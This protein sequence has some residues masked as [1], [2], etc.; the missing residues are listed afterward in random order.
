VC[1]HTAV[2][3]V[4]AFC[5]Y[6]AMF[7]FYKMYDDEGYHLW[8]LRLFATGHVLYN[9]VFSSYGPFPYELW[10]AI[11]KLTGATVSTNNGRLA[12]MALWL[13]TSVLLAVTT[14]RLTG[15]LTL[16]VVVQILSFSVLTP[17]V[18]EPMS[19]GGTGLL[20][21]CALLAVA[22][23]ALRAHPRRALSAIGALVAA[24]LL[25]KT[26]V[27]AYTALAVGYAA[28]MTL[29][30]GKWSKIVR[31]AAI[32]AVVF[33]GPAVMIPTF[34]TAWTR[35]FA[36]LVA[37]STVAVVLAT[38]RA[39]N[40]TAPA[41]ETRLWIGWML[42]GF[43]A[44]FAVILGVIFALGTTPR[45]LYDAV[46]VAASRQVGAFTFPLHQRAY[47]VGWVCAALGMAWVVRRVRT[48][49]PGQQ[50]WLAVFR[51]AAGL[52]LWYA[53]AGALRVGP[54]DPQLAWGLPLAWV[55]AV[56]SSR[57]D[58]SLACGFVRRLLPMLTVLQALIAYPVAGTQRAFGS[59]LLLVCGAIC[60]ADGWTELQTFAQS[61]SRLHTRRVVRVLVPAL[62]TAFA[63]VLAI[64]YVGRPARVVHKTYDSGQAL[65]FRS[66]TRL[67]L[68]PKEVRMYADLIDTLQARC[69]SV[70]TLPGMLSLNE[71]SG[72]P[73]PSGMTEQSWWSLLSDSQLAVA[74][75]SAESTNG[76]CLVRNDLLVHF[77]LGPGR[78]L[79]EIALVRFLEQEFVPVARNGFYTIS[80]RRKGA[81][82]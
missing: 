70:I 19:P 28:V 16:G 46:V 29:P 68:P 74:L 23:F 50:R 30:F 64:Q 65:P 75:R 11:S 54:A 26:N 40:T 57:D 4:S 32:A 66:A 42:G 48:G 60:V 81:R 7:S 71:W 52:G 56:P 17:F 76:L 27:G 24:A 63:M 39:D 79:P 73:A 72:L 10:A 47:M 53:V 34:D 8:S 55:A 9:D 38:A 43:S 58:G 12:T 20:V 36:L 6:W 1:V 41:G 59:V 14:R 3:V 35:Q 78:E 37:M 25:T 5:A 67:R 15:S 44:G 45:A 80:V 31:G 2:L 49:I 22:V 13:G 51:V 82:P 62:T 61:H 21:V 18:Q 77:W 33:I 69:R